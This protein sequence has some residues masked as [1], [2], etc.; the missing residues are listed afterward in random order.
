MTDYR[1]NYRGKFF[2]YILI[3]STANLL[4]YYPDSYPDQDSEYQQM[5]ATSTSTLMHPNKQYA[6][7]CEPENTTSSDE[8]FSFLPSSPSHQLPP[9][10]VSNESASSPLGR[11]PQ[12]RGPRPLPTSRSPVPSASRE[13]FPPPSHPNSSSPVPQLEPISHNYNPSYN[14]EKTFHE[15]YQLDHSRDIMQDNFKALALDVNID[16]RQQ[17]NSVSKQS[18]PQTPQSLTE[19]YYPKS[20][21]L[22][23]APASESNSP[24]KR[25]PVRR[26]PVSVLDPGIISA[27]P[28][29]ED[30]NKSLNIQ[31]AI[32][33]Q[34]MS[35]KSNRWQ[36]PSLVPIF[37]LPGVVSSGTTSDAFNTH[38]GDTRVKSPIFS[39]SIDDPPSPFPVPE[40][41]ISFVQ[42]EQA[43]NNHSLPQTNRHSIQVLP[44]NRSGYDLVTSRPLNPNT[45][46]QS[47]SRQR[48][49]SY[50]D[51][52]VNTVQ[53]GTDWR[54]PIT[55]NQ[56]EGV[57][58]E[59][60][61]PPAVHRPSVSST[62]VG[63][64]T[65]STDISGRP[66]QWKYHI[67]KNLKDFYMTTN[68]DS[69]HIKCLV[70]PS[71]YV[72]IT[73]GK[74]NHMGQAA[75]SISL[76][77]PMK[78][79]C[80]VTI[81]RG[82]HPNDE[83][84]YDIM[85]FKKPE[86]RQKQDFDF[87]QA[88]D[89][90]GGEAMVQ[91]ARRIS[92]G[93]KSSPATSSTPEMAWKSRANAIMAPSLAEGNSG[94]R[95]LRKKTS[96]RQFMLQDERGNKW[97]IGNRHEHHDP[98]YDPEDAE[99]EE[100]DDLNGNGHSV[101]KKS[102]KVYFFVPGPAGPA[103]DKIMAV[104][105]RRKQRHKKIMKDISKFGSVDDKVGDY[106]YDQPKRRNPFKSDK[107]QTSPAM[108]S[109]TFGDIQESHGGD[110]VIDDETAKFGWLTMYENVKRWQGMWPIVAGVTLAV[111]YGQRIDSK[112][113]S[114]AEKFKRLG[115]KYRESRMQVYY[116]HRHTQ[117]SI[118]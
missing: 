111:S 26:R 28:P 115:R 91:L 4:D 98:T 72:D 3:K 71:Y 34:P 5:P 6:R 24:V 96:M 110:G 58:E 66:K 104:L 10:E 25:K 79:F 97:I 95:L 89:Q 13:R 116:G 88:K 1:F 47:F 2:V 15:R 16:R 77:D 92:S 105:Q 35:D 99:E 23:H 81:S 45:S 93:F 56:Y 85:V 113:K 90:D 82:F 30:S 94:G 43:Y 9:T 78:Q 68:P 62:A 117:S 107:M 49:L 8:A 87:D 59:R 40:K 74:V 112:E 106:E 67:Q 39:E 84:F 54:H 20:P 57:A 52:G 46:A 37:P 7:N 36:P 64:P 108:V 73:V 22:N 42:R 53:P 65:M 86:S 103:S 76:V 19:S 55:R 114:V 11:S 27:A 14:T 48:P 12:L 51:G 101:T 102:T 44:S 18:D 50:I 61:A 60:D 118:Q 17:G 83:E 69:D 33:E 38:K 21:N 31:P 41:D 32:T 70:G 29:A 80:E 109:S 63:I 75:F 100:E